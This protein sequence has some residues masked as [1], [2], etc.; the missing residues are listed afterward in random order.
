MHTLDREAEQLKIAGIVDTPPIDL[1]FLTDDIS[2]FELPQ[3]IALLV[4]GGAPH[5]ME[6]RW[7][8]ANYAKLA[9]YLCAHRIV[10]VVIGGAAESSAIKTICEK[11]PLTINLAQRTSLGHVA[12]LARKARFAVGN[13]TGPMHVIAATQCPSFILFSGAS[14]PSQTAPRGQHVVVKQVKD[15]DT[16][17]WDSVS[18]DII[19]FVSFYDHES[20]KEELL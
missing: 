17:L 18:E 6:K 5:R 11:E 16:L 14:L 1:S 12:E 7:P 9:S 3:R 2:N 13:D 10:P 8:A 4:P 15:L 20:E 19:E